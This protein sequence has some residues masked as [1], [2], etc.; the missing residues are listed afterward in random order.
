MI[1]D[2]LRNEKGARNLVASA[3]YCNSAAALR[4][5]LPQQEGKIL[6][7]FR[8]SNAPSEPLGWSFFGGIAKDT[9]SPMEAVIREVKEELGMD[10]APSD[11]R[12]LAERRWV[13]P[14][15]GKEKIVYFYEGV[16]P[17]SWG[18]FFIKE[19]SGA[20]FLSK[21]EIAVLDGVSLLAKTF[22]A[23]YC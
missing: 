17:I 10:F 14:N 13:S 12:L 21:E 22:V 6:L 1:D 8:D 4:Y 5:H 2:Y 16:S 15:T 9:E 20:A 7:Q 3:I 19:G 11:V 18:D 23:E